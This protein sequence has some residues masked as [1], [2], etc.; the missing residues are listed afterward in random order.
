MWGWGGAVVYAALRVVAMGGPPRRGAGLVR[1]NH[2]ESAG[3]PLGSDCAGREVD[4]LTGRSSA[5]ASS[6]TNANRPLR[7]Y[8]TAGAEGSGRRR[9]SIA[10]P[11]GRRVGAPNWRPMR[12]DSA[13]AT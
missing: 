13:A 4:G 9:V 5:R 1:P 12:A 10:Q 11:S 7:R 6:A 2:G 3:P 8:A